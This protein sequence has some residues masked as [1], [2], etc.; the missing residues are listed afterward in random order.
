MVD[1]K[2]IIKVQSTKYGIL[3]VTGTKESIGGGQQVKG[4]RE[5]WV[6]RKGFTKEFSLKLNPQE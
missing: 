2:A 5:C 4:D 1:L 6:V 3:G